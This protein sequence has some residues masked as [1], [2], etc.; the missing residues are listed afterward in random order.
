MSETYTGGI[1]SFL[2][3]CMIL[4]YLQNIHEIKCD[5]TL[6]EHAI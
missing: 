4:I 6:G 3:S 5:L 1:G 2:L